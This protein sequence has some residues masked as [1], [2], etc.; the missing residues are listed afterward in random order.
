[1]SAVTQDDPAWL[2]RMYD[3]RAAVVDHL[4]YLE[5]WA[6]DS[7][8]VRSEQPCWIDLTYGKGHEETLDVFPAAQARAPVLVF[9]HGGHWRSLDKSGHSFLAPGFN[10][11]GVCVVLLNHALCPGMPDAPVTMPFIARQMEKA[12][13]WVWRHIGNHG[14]DRNRITLAGHGAGGHLASLLLTSPWPLL[15]SDLPEAPARKALSISGLHDLAPLMHTPSLQRDLRLTEQQVLRLSPA[16]LPAPA[17]A[18]LHCVV[19]GGESEEYLRQCRLM[20]EAWGSH[21]VPRCDVMPGLNHYSILDALAQPG[22]DVHHM[23]LNLLRA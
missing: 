14:G 12:L 5:R 15:A 4:D 17:Q 23:A 18:Q 1:M 22:H 6:R 13:A 10:A 9:I 21:A 20:R 7:A 3:N 19:G 8:R 2:E 11:A 16:L